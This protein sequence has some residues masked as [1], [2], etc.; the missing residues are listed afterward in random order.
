[1]HGN[2]RRFRRMGNNRATV[3]RGRFVFFL[4]F[5]RVVYP[6]ALQL[7][8]NAFFFTEVQAGDPLPRFF[9]RLGFRSAKTS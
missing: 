3:L 1:M 2:F 6:T 5:Y 9:L 4:A 7:E 8:I